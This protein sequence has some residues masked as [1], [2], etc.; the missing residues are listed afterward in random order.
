M[1]AFIAWLFTEGNPLVSIDIT[2]PFGSFDLPTLQALVG[3]F[4]S[5]NVSAL[6]DPGR[7]WLYSKSNNFEVG[8]EA[9]A[10]G[11]RKTHSVIIG[12]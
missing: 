11:E 9:I 4:P 12:E 3:E 8:R 2:D 6:L 1:G 10:R 5:M 7:E